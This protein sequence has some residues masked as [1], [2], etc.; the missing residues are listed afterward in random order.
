MNANDFDNIDL[1]WLNNTDLINEA[2]RQYLSNLRFRKAAKDN[3]Y[4]EVIDNHKLYFSTEKK[5]AELQMIEKPYATVAFFRL[6]NVMNI[7]FPYKAIL[8]KSWDMVLEEQLP[9]FL[10]AQSPATYI[11]NIKRVTHFLEDGHVRVS[12]EK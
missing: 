10:I 7:S 12:K 1:T 9:N 3:Y 2:N 8:T 11:S 4:I 5:Y 6:W